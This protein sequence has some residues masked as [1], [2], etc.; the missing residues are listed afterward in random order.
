MLNTQTEI[1]CTHENSNSF[2]A[3]V[4]MEDYQLPKGGGAVWDRLLGR[5][6]HQVCA[7]WDSESI[8]VS[9]SSTECG[10]APLLLCPAPVV[11]ASVAFLPRSHHHLALDLCCC[12]LSLTHAFVTLRVSININCVLPFIFLCHCSSSNL[13]KVIISASEFGHENRIQFLWT[14]WIISASHWNKR[15]ALVAGNCIG[16]MLCSAQG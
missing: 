11:C 12:H 3:Y 14:V 13:T 2:W 9:S 5:G 1:G 4:C 8:I 16:R 15:P 6:Q 7:V 10:A